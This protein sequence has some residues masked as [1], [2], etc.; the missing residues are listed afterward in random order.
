MKFTSYFSASAVKFHNAVGSVKKKKWCYDV[1]GVGLFADIVVADPVMAC[2][3][4]VAVAVITLGDVT[5]VVALAPCSC[6][7][8]CSMYI[9]LISR[10]T[11]ICRLLDTCHRH[12]SQ[13]TV[14]DEKEE[15]FINEQRYRRP[16]TFH[17]RT[18][19]SLPMLLVPF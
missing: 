19:S 17:K 6:F 13:E 3:A 2:R 10:L 18:H 14:L 4:S 8:F 15:R 16:V 12:Q 7:K 9:F 5:S 11:C 1:V